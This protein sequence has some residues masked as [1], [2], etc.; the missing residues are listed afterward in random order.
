VASPWE[1]AAPVAARTLLP[2]HERTLTDESHI[3]PDIVR[4]RGYYSLNSKMVRSLIQLEIINAIALS[5]DSWMG[6]PVVRPDGL[7]HA[8]LLRV[9]GPDAKVKY[10]WPTGV[11]N[12]V[13]V[14][15]ACLRDLQ[16]PTIPIILTEGIKKADAILTA[17]RAEGFACAVLAVNGCWG[18]KSSTEGGSIASRDFQDI[19]LS[20]RRIY[21]VSDSDF[22]TN[23]QVRAGWS[24][25]AQYLSSKTGEHRTFLVVVPPN[26]L[27]KQ[28]ADDYLAR[29]LTLFSLLAYAST[30]AHALLDIGAD[31]QPLHIKTGQQVIAEA[32]VEIPHLI[33]PLLPERGVVVLAG[34]SGTYKTW[35][36]LSLMLDGAFGLPWLDHPDLKLRDGGFTT[37]YI[38]KEM[39]GVMLATN[40]KL[41]AKNP[42]YA[43]H[44][45]Y[46]KHISERVFSTDESSLDLAQTVQ[47]DRLEESVR[48]LKIDLVVLDSLSMCWSG[49]ED[50]N[51]EV[52]VLYSQMRAMTERTGVTW[53]ILHHL[54]KPSSGTTKSRLPAKFTVR[55]AGQIIQ[56]AD[57]ALL[58]APHNEES[59]D[60]DVREITAEFVKTRTAGEPPTFISHFLTNDG[61]F[62]NTTYG[63]RVAEVAAREYAASSGDPVKF[64]AWFN[65]ELAKMPGMH[66]TGHG[67]RTPQLVALLQ[68]AWPDGEKGLPSERTLNR[69]FEMMV[70]LGELVLVAEHSK[71][72]NLYRFPPEPEPAALPGAAPPPAPPTLPEGRV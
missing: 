57:S 62:I 70:E 1:D 37:L 40:L 13:D 61:R 17:A 32:G 34:H 25:C 39:G 42:R 59:G 16:D 3:S 72:G 51:S 36:A 41:L 5:G 56:Q 43:K 18:W 19:P 49:N 50:S 30:P 48:G 45:D 44:P 52:G 4:E 2:E 64:I 66:P 65:A 47:R 22:R 46:D 7:V 28:G 11:R 35:H 24:S 31:R 12:A 53:L 69:R 67:L 71:Q 6:I 20:D 60:P 26:G 54:L 58:F 9:F 38:N 10:V 23:D 15:P 33:T 21:V 8:E 14:N 55:G 68:S 27:D 63:G 29:G